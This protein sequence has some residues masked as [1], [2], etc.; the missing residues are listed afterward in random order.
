ME[1]PGR[2]VKE[3][4]AIS[5]QPSET[6]KSLEISNEAAARFRQGPL[7]TDPFHTIATTSSESDGRLLE[8]QTSAEAAQKWTGNGF[9]RCNVNCNTLAN[10]IL[11]MYIIT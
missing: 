1:R 8:S 9:V 7:Q 6:P 3:E 11:D 2:H 5:Q 10:T 4:L